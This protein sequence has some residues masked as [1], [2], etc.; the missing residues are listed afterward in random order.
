MKYCNQCHHIFEDHICPYCQSKSVRDVQGDDYCFLIEKQYIWANMIKE[1]L[2][3][4]NIPYICHQD[5]GSALA[6]KVGP[7][8]E[9]YSFYVPYNHYTQAKNMVDEMFKR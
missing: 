1:Y 4:A 8:L 5:M 7:M 6:L 9:N 2:D 3:K